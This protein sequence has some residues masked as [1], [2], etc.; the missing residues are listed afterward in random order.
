MFRR[1]LAGSPDPLSSH[2]QPTTFL[3]LRTMIIS[4]KTGTTLGFSLNVQFSAMAATPS[5]YQLAR[6]HPDNTVVVDSAEIYRC[7]FF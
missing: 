4:I 6:V 1:T 2:I 5:R 3:Q 7:G